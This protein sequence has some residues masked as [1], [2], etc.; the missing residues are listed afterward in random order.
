MESSFHP[1][2]APGHGTTPNVGPRGTSHSDSVWNSLQ[3]NIWAGASKQKLNGVGL[4]GK[5]LFLG[6]SPQPQ[7]RKI[8]P[9]KR[10]YMLWKLG[11]VASKQK[12]LLGVGFHGNI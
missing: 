11:G 1:G 5:I 7:A 8:H 2:S 9:T 4:P 3:G 10:G 12:L 6:G